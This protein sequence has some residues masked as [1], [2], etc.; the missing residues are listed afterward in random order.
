M[1][2]ELIHKIRCFDTSIEEI[3]SQRLLQN[4]KLVIVTG[5]GTLINFK[6]IFTQTILINSMTSF[7]FDDCLYLV[8]DMY[9]FEEFAN[10]H[11]V[12]LNPLER[13]SIIHHTTH[14][15]WK[16]TLTSQSYFNNE[17]GN[18]S[19]FDKELAQKSFEF[20]SILD[21]SILHRYLCLFLEFLTFSESSRKKTLNNVQKSLDFAE[22][23][24]KY[25]LEL[26]S[27]SDILKR[28]VEHIIDDISSM[29]L[30]LGT[31]LNR[32]QE[33]KEA[34]KVLE[35]ERIKTDGLLMN[36]S[37]AVQQITSEIE[38]IEKSLRVLS[39]KLSHANVEYYQNLEEIKNIQRFRPPISWV[40]ES[41]YI[42]LFNKMID[43][44][45]QNFLKLF[46]SSITS[47][48]IFAS[49]IQ[50]FS[51]K[52]NLLNWDLI[53]II[54]Q[55]LKDALP[56][57]QQQPKNQSDFFELII[58]FIHKSIQ[59]KELQIPLNNYQDDL[60]IRRQ[61]HDNCLNSIHINDAKILD[62]EKKQSGLEE[63]LVS[64]V[65]LKIE[66]E[67]KIEEI[68]KRL[69][70]FAMLDETFDILKPDWEV[71]LEYIANY[72]NNNNGKK[73]KIGENTNR[74]ENK[75]T[76][77][78]IGK[79]DS[80]YISHLSLSL[81]I[82]A[83]LTIIPRFSFSDRDLLINSIIN[84]LIGRRMLPKA[85]STNRTVL[86]E[87][88]TSQ[89]LA[90]FD[91][92]KGRKKEAI[93]PLRIEEVGL[94]FRDQFIITNAEHSKQLSNIIK[95]TEEMS[96]LLSLKSKHQKKVTKSQT[97]KK[98]E[99]KKNILENEDL[100]SSA[101]EME[102]EDSLDLSSNGDASYHSNGES[103]SS[104]NESESKGSD[105]SD[106]DAESSTSSLSKDASGKSL[107]SDDSIGNNDDHN[108]Q[109]DS[110]SENSDN[111][112]DESSSLFSDF[113]NNTDNTSE[114]LPAKTK[115]SQKKSNKKIETKKKTPTKKVTE[116]VST[117][118]SK[119]ST[120]G[121]VE[122][123]SISNLS[124]SDSDD[125]DLFSDDNKS[126]VSGFSSDSSHWDDDGLMDYE[127][128]ASSDNIIVIPNTNEHV[129]DLKLPVSPAL[130][131]KSPSF[132]IIQNKDFKTEKNLDS[133]ASF[134]NSIELFNFEE[135]IMN[136]EGEE[137]DSN[138][139]S[140]LENE[141]N[142]NEDIEAIFNN[143]V[144]IVSRF[145]NIGKFVEGLTTEG[146]RTNPIILASEGA[147]A[148]Q[149]MLFKIERVLFVHDPISILDNIVEP[150]FET[151]YSI[152]F[153]DP[154]FTK[155]LL[156]HIHE[157]CVIILNHG[158]VE[159]EM[160]N[161]LNRLIDHINRGET[162]FSCNAETFTIH[163][164]LQIFLN[165]LEN[166]FCFQQQANSVYVTNLWVDLTFSINNLTDFILHTSTGSILPEFQEFAFSCDRI[167]ES[168]NGK[169]Q[170]IED[171]ILEVVGKS[172]IVDMVAN[173]DF[174]IVNTLYELNKELQNHRDT[175][176]ILIT[177][178]ELSQQVV[179]QL[180]GSFS[181]ATA[182]C[183]NTFVTLMQRRNSWST[184]VS[185]SFVSSCMCQY[186]VRLSDDD[187]FSI[188][189]SRKNVFELDLVKKLISFILSEFISKLSSSND[190]LHIGLLLLNAFE[191]ITNIEL[192]SLCKIASGELTSLSELLEQISVK[193]MG[194][195]RKTDTNVLNNWLTDKNSEG[196]F[197]FPNP[198]KVS[199][200]EKLLISA[201][202]K[203]LQLPY[204]INL[205]IKDTLNLPFLSNDLADKQFTFPLKPDGTVETAFNKSSYQFCL[206]EFSSKGVIPPD[207]VVIN[208][209]EPIPMG[210][211]GMV[212]NDADRHS[213]AV[214]HLLNNVPKTVTIYLVCSNND[215][216][217][218]PHIIRKMC[219]MDISWGS[220]N[221]LNWKFTIPLIMRSQL[222][223]NLLVIFDA[224]PSSFAVKPFF[225]LSIGHMALEIALS[226][227]SSEKPSNA[228]LIHAA[229]ELLTLLES[230]MTDTEVVN[231]IFDRCYKYCH[232]LVG[233]PN[234]GQRFFEETF[235]GNYWGMENPPI[236]GEDL[237]FRELKT[238][239][240]IHSK[241]LDELCMF[242]A[243]LLFTDRSVQSSQNFC[244][245]VVKVCAPL[246][247]EDD[248]SFDT[249]IEQYNLQLEE[250]ER[251]L[252]QSILPE[253]DH[254]ING[255]LSF[256][257]DFLNTEISFVEHLRLMVLESVISLKKAHNGTILPT[258]F[259]FLFYSILNDLGFIPVHWLQSL[260]KNLAFIFPQSCYST[261]AL[262]ISEA[263][264]ISQ[265]SFYHLLLEIMSTYRKVY[266]EINM[267]TRPDIP[268]IFA[269]TQ[270]NFGSIVLRDY[271]FIYLA[272]VASLRFNKIDY[273][274]MCVTLTPSSIIAER[275]ED[276]KVEKALGEQMASLAS[277]TVFVRSLGVTEEG[278]IS[279]NRIVPT[280]LFVS[281]GSTLILPEMS[282]RL[283]PSHKLSELKIP[284]VEVHSFS[285]CYLPKE[286]FPCIAL[287]YFNLKDVIFDELLLVTDITKF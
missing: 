134:G 92:H 40:L 287:L 206:L 129:S 172:S 55:K 43:E 231:V 204:F 148:L 125:D 35:E 277:E 89:T 152:S 59:L 38:P 25:L 39:H 101:D 215:I 88:I 73:N 155:Q 124:F 143:Y 224:V 255:D 107:S 265:Q 103:G 104:D 179:N 205:L 193:T 117:K 235:N 15:F 109:S 50:D 180:Y 259:E 241:K 175:L 214:L 128:D 192:E 48:P 98:H 133:Q 189:M 54:K 112:D 168:Y 187:R 106:S 159:F 198:D 160:G 225:N 219:Y 27:E 131:P 24:K 1:Q 280:E 17:N 60:T 217:S 248:Y 12:A 10:P 11:V 157:D 218:F 212:I 57:I 210:I 51:K 240:D 31:E 169:R 47:F 273:S 171:E 233:I 200:G 186:V 203:P 32:S 237:T 93:P 144:E 108:E 100:F 284:F 268:K 29:T 139:V 251:E 69:K 110:F 123:K 153:V 45:D 82:A 261:Q 3:I 14:T 223:R 262:E 246:N 222:L 114:N 221:S 80:D 120:R 162:T 163:P 87:L 270:I 63:Q 184:I 245:E 68:E 44:L 142:N 279:K 281:L 177:L 65:N 22:N 174:E 116:E 34:R 13:D 242:L 81:V 46:K 96:D 83:M 94:L 7:D 271:F 166:P 151:I 232:S 278:Y 72:S 97:S 149:W 6:Q 141:N 266:D 267:T 229:M 121:N 226:S 191:Y 20:P 18:F 182:S 9:L 199:C 85:M 79:N 154:N 78:I 243:D 253:K 238:W 173:N 136:S 71:Q 249:A 264:A 62:V 239:M 33:A 197:P 122:K 254:P 234:F 19:A 161:V 115:K 119:G 23:V 220:V 276:L 113:T 256:A 26:K 244:K 147:D 178:N 49:Q 165:Y 58:D 126:S 42:I 105:D 236:V 5:N 111:D 118:K 252:S 4:L 52:I 30:N 36:A 66:K 84:D 150:L 164:N 130:T 211:K 95:P 53:S 286:Q 247:F 21:V 28:E 258:S 16:A 140:Q 230:N 185:A 2:D 75:N 188:V 132:E 183:V 194:Q 37:R 213:K 8:S 61:N 76:P 195:I 201:V 181:Y 145:I 135:N 146:Y 158:S 74:A 170:K 167:V 91:I 56:L 209:Y 127:S 196:F 208:P 272:I 64:A 137:S 86:N 67:T 263:A 102:E 41:Y 283:I 285:C 99:E 190:R 90:Y 282:V 176:V 227:F 207:F 156:S 250:M 260:R 77:Q 269:K 257:C 275:I 274:E 228:N 70:E 138:D 216:T 202:E